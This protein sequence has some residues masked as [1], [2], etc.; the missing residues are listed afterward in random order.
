LQY[1]AEQGLNAFTDV[2]VPEAT[3]A[4]RQG[5]GRLIRDASD[6]GLVMIAD[7]RLRS[8]PYGKRML[9]SLPPMQRI[10]DRQQAIDWLCRLRQGLVVT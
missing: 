3:I 2:Q 6:R 10:T 5:V 8:K 1:A 4:L 7:E 9:D